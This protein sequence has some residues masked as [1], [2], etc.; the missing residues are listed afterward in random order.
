MLDR[1]LMVQCA[2]LVHRTNTPFVQ[3]MHGHTGAV[4]GGLLK[5][6][7]N[8]IDVAQLLGVL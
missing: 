7:K 6:T 3:F 4:C 5:G 8:S 2:G 1:D